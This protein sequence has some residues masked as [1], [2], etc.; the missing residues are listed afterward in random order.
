VAKTQE[1]ARTKP[2][3]QRAVWYAA[4][5]A[6]VVGF[7]IWLAQ[8]PSP[9]TPVAVVPPFAS[10][11][12]EQSSAARVEQPAPAPSTVASAEPSPLTSAAPATSATGDLVAVLLKIRPEG[13]RVYYRGK[14][15]GRSPF[16]LELPRGET[17]AYEV[18]YPGYMTRRLVVDGTEP[19]ISISMAPAVK[20][21]ASGN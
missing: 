12:T 2:S 13:A 18:G 3:G 19:V 8:G 6:L 16:T 4:L 11:P 15:V 21:A 5:A 20:P 7:G 10:Q 17:R 9:E 14:E 1:P